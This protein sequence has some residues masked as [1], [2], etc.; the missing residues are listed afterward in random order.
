[1]K[2]SKKLR[3][4]FIVAFLLTVMW[5]NVA[6]ANGLAGD[7]DGNRMLDIQDVT[8]LIGKVLNGTATV[9]D[10]CE[11]DGRDGIDVAD[12]IEL[13]QEVL[14][15]TGK[16]TFAVDGHLFSLVA[17]EGGTF[18]MGS[19]GSDAIYNERPV[20]SVT[21]SSFHI[22]QVEVTQALWSAVMGNNPS[23]YKGDN[24]PVH[25]VTWDNCQKFITKLNAL[26]GFEFRMPTEA[27]WEYAARGG[28]LTHG[29]KYA[30]SNSLDDVAWYMANAGSQ[31]LAVATKLPNELGLY[32][33]SGNVREW[34]QDYYADYTG[35]SQVDPTGPTQDEVIFKSRV[36]RGGAYNNAATGCRVTSRSDLQQTN[37]SMSIGMRLAM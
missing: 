36:N 22:A 3:A 31:P 2:H 26:T 12:V 6:L 9:N 5:P 28:Q 18:S 11:V 17:V 27:E 24:L 8:L 23:Y 34:C 25:R 35:T 20:H 14:N 15:P 37:S 13:I 4:C 33:M 32:D 1:M 21:L 30:G 19:T 7:V 29:Y 10:N 16:M